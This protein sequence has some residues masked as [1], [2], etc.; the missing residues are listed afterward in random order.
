[1]RLI[2]CLLAILSF[3]VFAQEPEDKLS[4]YHSCGDLKDPYSHSCSCCRRV[5]FTQKVIVESCRQTGWDLNRC[6]MEL[7]SWESIAKHGWIDITPHTGWFHNDM[8]SPNDGKTILPVTDFCSWSGNAHQVQC[9]CSHECKA[10]SL[11]LSNG[12]IR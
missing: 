12:E 4:Q 11:K 9:K 8:L 10:P 7:P 3:S 5:K 1:M 6:L 2:L